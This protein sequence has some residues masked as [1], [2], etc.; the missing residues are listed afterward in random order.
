MYGRFVGLDI[1]SDT[2]KITLIKRG[3]RDTDLIQIIQLKSPDSPQAT[4]ELLKSVFTEKFLPKS[5][6]AT[7]LPNN[8]ISIRVLSFPFSDPNKIDQIYEFEL[9]N[10]SPFDPVDKV[11]GYYLIK[12]REESEAI[13]C[14][15]EKEDIRRLIDIYQSGGIN[16]AYQNSDHRARRGLGL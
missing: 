9:E 4:S 8:P 11:H 10:V 13:V 2:I 16:P 1:G 5:D 14:M 12:R 3:F 15:S 6:I 7:S